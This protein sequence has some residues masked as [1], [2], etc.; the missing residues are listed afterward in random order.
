[1]SHKDTSRLKD[2]IER[3]RP[4]LEQYQDL[5]RELHADPELSGQEANSASKISRALKEHQELEVISNLGGHGVVGIFKNGE[6]PVVLLI[7]ELDALPLEE[8]TSLPYASKK[9]MTD[10]RGN[11]V[12]VLHGCG[13]DIHMASLLAAIDLVLRARSAW[14]GTL[15]ALFQPAEET[16]QGAQAML[17]DGLYSKIPRPS[18]LLAQNTTK[19]KAGRVL[20]STGPVMAVCESYT[21]RVHGK[22]ATAQAYIYASTQSSLARTHSFAYNRLVVRAECVA[23]RLERELDIERMRCA[24]PTVNDDC[25]TSILKESLLTV[26]GGDVRKMEPDTASEEFSMLARPYNIP[27]VYWNLGSTD[28]ETWDE[29]EG[30]GEVDGIPGNH[31]S[32]FRPVVEES[33]RRGMDA[34][35]VATLTFLGEGV[36]RV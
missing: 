25:A 26:F 5:Y 9:H 12:P 3:N 13:H 34:M 29:A 10:T 22:T 31:S 36:G 2:I 1:M 15:I 30:K 23:S 20:I 35:A 33:L 7:S 8:R 32:E 6:G 16:F 18:I 17:N 11:I 19:D 21:I 27:Y 28:P 4:H 24:P 14:S